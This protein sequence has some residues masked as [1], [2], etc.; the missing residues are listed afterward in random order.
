[1]SDKVTIVDYGAGNLLSVQ[2]AFEKVG[3]EVE[4]SADH[5]LI[6]NAERLVLPGV[7]A[8]GNCAA[9]LVD[10]GLSEI[11]KRYAERER[12]LLGICVGMQLL[13]EESEEFGIHRGLGIINGRVMPIPTVDVE[14]N[15]HKIPHI[16]WSPLKL[17]RDAS[18]NLWR[19]TILTDVSPDACVYFVH[20]YTAM[21][22]STTNR[23]A[24]A[25]YNGRLVSAAIS[26]GNISAT[27]FHPEKSGVVGL[28][29]IKNFM[30]R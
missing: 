15:A 5:R 21:P 12:P 16:G 9:R 25:D 30:Q 26:H 7:G 24:D 27:Q 1:M 14:G 13:L 19:G 4:V 18:H 3:A 20:S 29:I 17:P 8:F 22:E 2:R 11:L 28:Q 6:A 10:L 23:L